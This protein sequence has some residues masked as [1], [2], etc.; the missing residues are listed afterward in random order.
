MSAS[1]GPPQLVSG[2]GDLKNMSSFLLFLGAGNQYRVC[3]GG[4]GDSLPPDQASN[5]VT[6]SH[7][8]PLSLFSHLLKKKTKTHNLCAEG[9]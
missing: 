1:P 2:E 6:W 5:C 8:G 7:L 4:E 3:Q 9:Y